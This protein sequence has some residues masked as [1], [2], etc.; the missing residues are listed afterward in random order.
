MTFICK[1]RVP[2]AECTLLP[3]IGVSATRFDVPNKNLITY[4]QANNVTVFVRLLVGK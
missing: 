3:P 2:R 1:A 4:L